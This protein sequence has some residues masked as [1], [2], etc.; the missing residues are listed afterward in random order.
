MRGARQPCLGAVRPPIPVVAPLLALSADSRTLV[1]TNHGNAFFP[2]RNASAW[3]LF[4]QLTLAEAKTWLDAHKAHGFTSF[5]AQLLSKVQSNTPNNAANNAPF[6]GAVITSTLNAAYW[7]HIKAVLQ[8]AGS[9]GMV[10]MLAILYF[11]SGGDA[12]A[13][14]NDFDGW[15]TEAVVAGASAVTTYCQR[16]EAHLAPC[17]NVV[18]ILGGD[19]S[20]P[21]STIVN[22]IK[23]GLSSSRLNTAHYA[24]S[25]G[26]SDIA[27]F[28]SYDVNAIY[29]WNQHPTG[30]ARD[31]WNNHVK[32]VFLF[33]GKYQN[34][35]DYGWSLP[36]LCEQ[37]WGPALE[38]IAGAGSSNEWTWHGD[39]NAT[40]HVP[41]Q[42]VLPVGHTWTEYLGQEYAVY[43]QVFAALQDSI[44]WQTMVPSQGAA[45]VTSSRGTFDSEQ[46]YVSAAVN[47]SGGA[48]TATAGVVYTAAGASVTIAMSRFAG[49]VTARRIDPTTG[50]TTALGTFANSGTQNFTTPGNNAGGFA[51]WVFAFTA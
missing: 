35:N 41:G 15:Y 36:L 20:P 22:A 2:M 47:D 37:I 43:M 3:L 1:D 17:T 12:N 13:G 30:F 4:N 7:D 8:Y 16:V 46:G 26:Y 11:G 14:G 34:N 39:A 28:G 10:G 24:A 33:E 31:A 42:S 51:A 25:A 45:F 23:A 9:I 5:Y 49:T 27:G 18:W 29:T 40:T 6:T 50:A 48:G 21:N 32:P 44:A 38:G 19:F